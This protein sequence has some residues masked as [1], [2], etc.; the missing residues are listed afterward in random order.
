MRSERVG[1]GTRKLELENMEQHNPWLTIWTQPRSTIARIVANNPNRSLWWLAGIY[2]FCS[3]MNMFQSMAL[4][5]A[6]SPVGILILAIVI[7][8]LWG[9]INFSLW[10][11]FVAW[12]GKWL[13]GVG[14]FTTVRSAYAWSCVPIIVN[15]PL[16][17]LMVVLFGQ[18]LFL[19]FPDAHLMPNNQ[20]LLLFGI[21][22]IKV[23]LAIWSLIIFLNTLAEVQKFSI[24]RAILNV[25]IAGV[26]LGI[27]LFVV[28]SVLFY[29]LGN[30][31]P[32]AFMLF[33][34][35]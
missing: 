33:K 8:P 4:G 15:I 6:M 7:A 34:P 10:S 24:L 2:G 25:I 27:V 16:W 29:A 1:G 21:L 32:T 9:W 14:T 12:V 31:G 5:S 13:K 28:W 19:N 35:F 23:I 20:M 17:L 22:I 3:L 18:Q 30:V 26:I 11:V